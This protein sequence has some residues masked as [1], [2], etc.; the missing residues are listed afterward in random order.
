MPAKSKQYF[1]IL[2]IYGNGMHSRIP[3]FSNLC[4]DSEISTC[5][6]IFE[7]HTNNPSSC[8]IDSKKYNPGGIIKR[9]TT[10][11]YTGFFQ[12]KLGVTRTPSDENLGVKFRFPLEKYTKSLIFRH[13]RDA[14]PQN[15]GV[16][17]LNLGVKNPLKTPKK[18]RGQ[19]HT[20]DRCSIIIDEIPKNIESHMQA[21]FYYRNKNNNF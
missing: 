21:L 3:F 7:S 2:D 1:C 12:K 10:D 5:P 19:I 6:G 14:Q 4:Q 13:K 20:T 11:R 16:T 18:N 15:L 9:N 17:R 8:L